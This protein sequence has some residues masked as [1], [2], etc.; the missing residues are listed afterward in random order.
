MKKTLWGIILIISLIVISACSNDNKQDLSNQI[1]DDETALFYV[2][3][4]GDGTISVI[5]ASTAETVDTISLG[6]EQASH[7]IALSLDGKVLYTGTGFDG[8]SVI[9][10]DTETKEILDEI[11]FEE[12]VHGIDLSP[13][14]E[15]L[16]VSLNPGLGQTG[17]KLVIIDTKKMEVVTDINTGD[18]PAH[19]AVSPDGSQ[20]WSANVNANSVSVIDTNTKQLIATIK[21]GDVPNEVAISPDGKWAY[22]A[23]V[24]SDIVSVIDTTLLQTVKTIKAGDGPHGVTVSPSGEELWVSN[25]NSNDVTVVDTA[26]LTTK[27]TI[28]TGSYAN[29]VAFSKDGKWAYVTNRQSNDVVKIDTIK[30]EE[31]TRI[32][33]GNEPHEISLEDYVSSN[34]KKI[35]YS[36]DNT[37]SNKKTED[38]NKRI[39]EADF[40]VV[41]ALRLSPEDP[42]NDSQYNLE[43]NEVFEISIETHSGDLLSLALEEELFLVNGEGN[44]VAPSEWIVKNKDAH[45]PQFIA[46]FPKNEDS[47]VT[48]EIGKLSD[49]PIELNWD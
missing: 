16:Y 11:K 33:V 3:N 32:P 13:D 12:G 41:K 43:T 40:A 28:P 25:N 1:T 24:E 37:N 42:T 47:Q 23:N 6:T 45:H 10:I 18:A 30:K 21:V 46:V 49:T 34:F 35:T 17:G 2:P 38:N 5:D 9:V 22:V 27:V 48:L 29:H 8:K 26:T 14:G 31:V 15:F 20:V 39:A 7:G 4:A 36:F 44:K 19:V